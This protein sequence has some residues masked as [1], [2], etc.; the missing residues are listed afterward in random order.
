MPTHAD[1]DAVG[2]VSVA[3]SREPR[4]KSGRIWASSSRASLAPVGDWVPIFGAPLADSR[5]VSALH[6]F[7][8]A[9]FL[10]N[11]GTVGTVVD[12]QM[13][14]TK[15]QQAALHHG[16]ALRARIGQA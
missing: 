14:D 4:L 8:S 10:T 15:G 3:L 5:S 2:W 7:G 11:F 12:G 16:A 9:V 13:L 1:A 6:C